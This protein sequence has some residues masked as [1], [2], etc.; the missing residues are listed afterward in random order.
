MPES[1]RCDECG[2]SFPT[3]GDALQHA[4]SMHGTS[5]MG[6]IKDADAAKKNRDEADVPMAPLNRRQQ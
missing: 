4:Q 6:D 1:F 5:S 3:E 2:K